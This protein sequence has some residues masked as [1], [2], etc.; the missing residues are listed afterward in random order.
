[1]SKRFAGFLLA[2]AVLVSGAA[3]LQAA[4]SYAV[5]GMH[6]CVTFKISHLGLSWVHGRFN[7]FTGTFTLDDDPARCAFELTIKVASIDT[8]NKKRDGHLNSPDFFNAKQYPDI[9][10]KSTAVK[11]IKDG[12]EVTGDLEMHGVKKPVTFKF[13]GGRK[14]EFPK[15]V[16]RTGYSTELTIKRSDFGMVDKQPGFLGDEVPIA[17]S[18][19]AVRK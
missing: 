17:I 11:A 10:F 18:L 16:Q 12:Y 2:A 9:T 19:Q 8:A 3:P 13:L 1:M 6:S 7:E 5:D 14:A 15:G 4:D